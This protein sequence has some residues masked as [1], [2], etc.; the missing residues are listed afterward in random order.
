MFKH[1]GSWV[2]LALLTLVLAL[3]GCAGE[4]GK[5][6]LDGV[7]GQNGDDGDDGAQGPTGPPGTA[8]CMECHTDTFGEADFILPISMWYDASQHNQ[9]DTYLRSGEGCARCH[10][11]EGFQKYLAD[12]TTP[13]QASASRISCF[14]CHAPHTRLD[15]SL[16]KSGATSIDLGGG[17]YDK[18]ASNTCVVCHQARVPVPAIADTTRITSSRWGPHHS[19]QGNVLSGTGAYV[20]EGASYPSSEHRSGIANGCVGCH[21]GPEISSSSGEGG[22]HSFKVRY[23]SSALINSRSCTASCH[24]A[25]RE[26]DDPDDAAADGVDAFQADINEKLETLKVLLVAKGWV[27]NDTGLLN[28]S[29]TNPLI[30]PVA[31]DRGALFNYYFIEEDFSHGA[32]NPDYA[33]AVLDATID[34]LTP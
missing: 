17:T 27:N 6:G 34:Y 8:E 10:T 22:G 18:G 19:T 16:R 14:T 20:F 24:S 12:G 7:N 26:A 13:A 28:A 1:R 23:G 11:N 31:A 9:G 21:M 2:A 29:A 15:F 25:W 5:D 4:D 30:L 3:A 32:H 33:E